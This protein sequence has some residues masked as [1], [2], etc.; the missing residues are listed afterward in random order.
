LGHFSDLGRVL[1]QD[2]GQAR[3]LGQVLGQAEI[4]GDQGSVQGRAGPARGW[5]RAG[6]GPPRGRSRG[7]DRGQ[8]GGEN[9]GAGP[10]ATHGRQ[11]RVGIP[12]WSTCVGRDRAGTTQAA[13]YVLFHRGVG[14][15]K[16]LIGGLCFVSPRDRWNQTTHWWARGGNKFRRGVIY[17]CP[18][19][20]SIG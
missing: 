20:A 4:R 10:G 2:P 14:G 17:G 15:T 7:V 13:G 1:G 12:P 3:D 11:G 18:C 5:S 9:S 6:L 16:L 8:G 19:R